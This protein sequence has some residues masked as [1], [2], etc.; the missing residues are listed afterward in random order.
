MYVPIQSND[1]ATLDKMFG[2]DRPKYLGEV[3]VDLTTHPLYSGYTP[4]DWALLW[5]EMYGQTDGSHHK[6]WVL[7][8]V[9]R[10]LHGTKMTACLASWDNGTTEMRFDLEE[11]PSKAYDDWVE[12]MLGKKDEDG[13]YEYDYDVGIAP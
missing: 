2:K 12:T 11:P 9:A 6:T 5:L 7:D 13:E 3:P 10:I 8:Q 1:D 4:K